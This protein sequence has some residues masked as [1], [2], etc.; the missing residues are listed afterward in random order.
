V[1]VNTTTRRVPKITMPPKQIATIPI[2]FAAED[3]FFTMIGG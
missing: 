3:F 1:E 2:I